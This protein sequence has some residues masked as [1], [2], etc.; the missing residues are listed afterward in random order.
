[1]DSASHRI[2]QHI[3]GIASRLKSPSQSRFFSGW[4]L[5]ALFVASI[6]AVPI[7]TITTYIF[8]PA[9]SVWSHLVDTVLADYVINSVV[10]MLGVTIGAGII[11]VSTAWLTAMYRFPG[12]RL[13]EW[14][15]L[16]PLAMPTYII[17]YIYTDFL[18]VAGPVQQWIQATFN[19]K[20][21]E[22]YFPDAR[23]LGGAVLVF[24]LVLYPYVYLMARAAFLSQSVCAL[25]VSRSLGCT[26]F[27]SFTK[28]AL[29]LARPAIIAG[30]SLTLMETLADFGAVDYFGI[31]TFTTGIYRTWFGLNNDA[32]A[33]QLAATMMLFVFVLFFMERWSRQGARFHHASNRYQQIPEVHLRGGKALLST[34]ACALPLLLGF[35]LPFVQ[36]GRWAEMTWSEMVDS[37]FINLAVNSF[38]LASVTA[39]LALIPALLL[40]YAQRLY[41]AR[42]LRIIVRFAGMGY[43]IPGSVIA[44]GVLIP[45]GLLDNY[46][47]DIAR[48]RFD[49]STGLLF[50]G[51]IFI[52]IFA[53]MVRFL[54]VSLQSVESGLDSIRPSMDQAALSMGATPLG[55]LK[56]VHFPI[57]KGTL[58]TAVLLVFVDVLKELPATMILRPF[59]FNTLAVRVHELASDERLADSS[60]AAIAIVLVG[61]VPV[62]L[63]SKTIAR[64]RPG[65]Q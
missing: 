1:M 36:L 26:P 59:N 37:T 57:M 31:S 18:E 12:C 35:V 27:E 62:I 3:E 55:V 10:L 14:A 41:P 29:P 24:S 63:L 51:T 15:L 28:V 6:I 21:G 43:A 20:Y 50:S 5:V 11:G 4:L 9:G 17:A 53:Y 2:A 61:L 13:F 23:S 45:F 8:I 40:A 39:I 47:D 33:A 60:T 48:D 38:S 46:I 19:L 44:V 52:L 64:S 34:I 32:A 7:A 58:L 16:L 22:Y 30:L 42:F 65:K 49:F 54:A 56:K 25:E